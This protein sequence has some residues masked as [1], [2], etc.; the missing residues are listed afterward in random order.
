MA[1]L[2]HDSDRL[3]KLNIEVLII[4]PDN[5]AAFRKFWDKENLPFIGLPDPDHIVSNLYA[6]KVKILKLGR[7]PAQMLVDKSGIIIHFHYGTSMTDIP[8]IDSLEKLILASQNPNQFP[9]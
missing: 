7:L 6:Q 1:Q 5:A 9:I 2:R 3:I 4:G 8:D